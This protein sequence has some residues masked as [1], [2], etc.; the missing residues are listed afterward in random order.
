MHSALTLIPNDIHPNHLDGAWSNTT[1]ATLHGHTMGTYWNLRW[2]TQPQHPAT[3]VQQ[4]LQRAFDLVIRQMSHYDPTSELSRINLSP[5][6]QPH[7]L[8]PEFFH[9]L[10]EA[11]KLSQLTHGI[12]HPNLGELSSSYGF[13]PNPKNYPNPPNPHPKPWQQIHLNPTHHTLTHHY[14][15][16]HLDLSSIAKGYALDLAAIQLEA[17]GIR[18]FLLEIGGEFLARGCKPDAQPWW[19]E[20]SAPP[21][22]QRLRFALTHHALA[23]S[24]PGEQSIHHLLDPHQSRPTA[25]PLHSVTVL[26]S[27][28]LQADAY[29][30]A[31]Y[32]LGPE[33]GPIFAQE[34]HLT[35]IF[36]H[37][38]HHHFTTHAKQLLEE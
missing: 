36:T 16:L 33:Q 4:A 2:Q 26:A 24:G 12:Y 35:A 38:T 17:L 20:L 15:R 19:I 29:A 10:H 9:V 34:H 31:L 25:H 1:I 3:T 7:R 21:T 13:G 8:S 37:P 30:T 5:P 23:T 28:C 14:Q 18:H 6:H 27:T 32:L 22:L 11:L